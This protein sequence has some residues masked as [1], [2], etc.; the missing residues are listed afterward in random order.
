MKN[1]LF[2]IAVLC[3]A[4]GTSLP[5]QNVQPF[6]EIILKFL[7]DTPTGVIPKQ[8][9]PSADGSFLVAGYGQPLGFIAKLNSPVEQAHSVW[10]GNRVERYCGI[11]LGRTGSR[12]KMQ[13]LR[14]ERRHDLEGA[15]RKNRC[16]GASNCL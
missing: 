1:L 13:E 11:A 6:Q 7:D 5:A 10:S 9:I 14:H 3:I 4:A 12:R 8:I 16:D 15:G 2:L